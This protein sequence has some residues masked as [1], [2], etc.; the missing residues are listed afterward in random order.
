M[1]AKNMMLGAVA[2]GAM[3]G[4]VSADQTAMPGLSLDK[5][6]VWGEKL[7][8]KKTTKK[9]CS[10]RVESEVNRLMETEAAI[11]T[12]RVAVKKITKKI[13]AA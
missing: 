3:V 8:V 4:Q 12:N 1:N 9:I 7:A 6:V 2:M 5:P 11:K 13:C 10:K